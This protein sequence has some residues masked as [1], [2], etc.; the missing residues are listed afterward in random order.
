ME[1]T[2]YKLSHYQYMIDIDKDGYLI[3]D[4]TGEA[5]DDREYSMS[6]GDILCGFLSRQ[7]YGKTIPNIPTSQ[8][9]SRL[10]ETITKSSLFE[11]VLTDRQSFAESIKQLAFTSPNHANVFWYFD[12]KARKTVS[13]IGV[14]NLEDLLILDCCM[15]LEKN[16]YVARCP[17]CSRCIHAKR[18]VKYCKEHSK[19]A[20]LQAK[21]DKIKN[22]EVE[23]LRKLI[24]DRLYQRYVRAGDWGQKVVYDNFQDQFREKQK[25]LSR[26]DLIDWLSALEEDTKTKK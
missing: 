16:I 4:R 23:R 1:T 8:I 13:V 12:T 21:K 7:A 11:L 26:E 9:L 20:S 25:T 14:S 3:K 10:I 18:P 24:R 19:Q 2:K 22:D 15:V 5:E 6:F 17:V